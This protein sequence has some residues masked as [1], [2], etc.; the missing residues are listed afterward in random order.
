MTIDWFKLKLA[1]NYPLAARERIRSRLLSRIKIGPLIKKGVAEAPPPGTI[2]INLT[3]LCN[4]RCKMCGQWRRKDVYRKEIL[5]L[6]KLKGMI[7][8][9]S[10]AHPKMYLWGGEPLLYPDF[11]GL[12]RYLKDKKQ[13]TIINTNG[14]LLKRYAAELVDLKVDGLDISIDGP[15]A[16]HDEIRGVPH[17]FEKVID[18]LRVLRECRRESGRRK[19]MVKAICTISKMNQDHLEETL[20]LLEST[21]LFDAV[22]FNLGWFTTEKIGR[23]TDRIFQKHLGCGSTSWKDFVGAL[24]NVD[25]GK[26]KSFMERVSSRRR[27]GGLP[28]FF[29]PSLDPGEVGEY[30]LRPSSFMGRKKCSSPWSNLEIRPNGDA[31]FCPDFP[32]YIIGNILEEPFEKIWNGEKARKFRRLLIENG[33][34]PLCSRCCGLYI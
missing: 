17:T 23:A 24:G 25:P 7:D 2:S 31:T 19:P 27:K 18:G 14:V 8:D 6:E 26:V 30:Y 16:I 21:G 34:F 13:Y 15:P 20:D 33:L 5:P 9:L 22:I 28:V 12:I 10:D 3:H 29:I 32:D 11:S 4:L 1:A